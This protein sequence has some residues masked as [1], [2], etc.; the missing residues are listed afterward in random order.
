MMTLLRIDNI[1]GP[2][3]MTNLNSETDSELYA[4]MTS[5]LVLMQKD[6]RFATRILSAS[7]LFMMHYKDTVLQEKK[8]PC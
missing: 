2:I 5:I 4:V 6:I 3:C 1:E 8:N 7:A